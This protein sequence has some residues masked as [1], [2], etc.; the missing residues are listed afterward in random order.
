MNKAE[1][2]QIVRIGHQLQYLTNEDEDFIMDPSHSETE[3]TRRMTTARHRSIA[4]D[5]DRRRTIYAMQCAMKNWQERA[6]H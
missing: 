1:R 6:L 4:Q 2:K 3:V 5:E